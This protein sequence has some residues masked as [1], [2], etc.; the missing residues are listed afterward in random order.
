M[1]AKK[2]TV[3]DVFCVFL[4]EIYEI[5]RSTNVFNVLMNGMVVL[6]TNHK[7]SG[8]TCKS[9]TRNGTI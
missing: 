7:L 4:K 2:K 5:K 9:K 6:L 1:H 3:P 8:T